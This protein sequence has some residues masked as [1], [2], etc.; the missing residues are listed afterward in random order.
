MRQFFGDNDQ[1]P[2]MHAIAKQFGWVSANAAHEICEQLVR[3]G[4]IEKNAVGK[5]RF[6]RNK[7]SK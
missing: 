4:Y 1:L 7:E 2:P 5:Y 6:V 3:K